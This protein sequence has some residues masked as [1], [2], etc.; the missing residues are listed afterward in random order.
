MTEKLSQFTQQTPTLN[1]FVAG[2]NAGS[3]NQKYILSDVQKVVG[4]FINA[5][6]YGAIGDGTTDNAT[7][8]QTAFASLGSG[9]TLYIPPGTF[10]STSALNP[11]SNVTVI[12]AG[13]GVTKIAVGV[14]S[15]SPF[16]CGVL[17]GG[18]GGINPTTF[19]PINNPII[20]GSSTIT[21]T[22][23]ANAGNFSI[24]DYIFITGPIVGNGYYPSWWTTVK[25]TNAGTGV[26]TLNEPLPFGDTLVN[27]CAKLSSIAQNIKVSGLSVIQ[28]Q[29]APFQVNFAQNVIIE[30][31]S[32][33]SVTGGG[34]SLE[35]DNCRDVTVLNSTSSGLQ[36]FWEAGIGSWNITFL[37]IIAEGGVF[38]FDGGCYD[39]AMINC[40]SNNPFAAAGAG[41]TVGASSARN[42]VIGCAALNCPNTC[43]GILIQGDP[44]VTQKLGG[45]LIVGNT[46][47]GATASGSDGIVISGSNNN[48]VTGNYIRSVNAGIRSSNGSLN[49]ALSLNSFDMIALT[50]FAFDTSSTSNTVLTPTFYNSILSGTSFNVGQG[51]GFTVFQSGATN[52][53]AFTGG[54]SGQEI[55]L[56]FGDSNTTLINVSSAHLAGGVNYNP[57]ANTVMKFVCVGSTWFEISRSND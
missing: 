33:P 27:Q 39:S 23:A 24:G 2:A 15:L 12:G 47:T 16:N 34:N 50:N 49:T 57:P 4:T 25:S 17:I 5:Q 45:N 20:E 41:I 21:T 1:S 53:S 30:N 42:R 11:P 10:F 52:V 7:A 32:F 9:G 48:V 44:A 19:Y 6:N 38:L 8:F 3:P 51:T 29:N 26:I 35:V 43:N 37:N 22:T 46:I 56:Y 28:S 54:T 55:T 13:E 36:F 18:N 40:I 14:G 31:V